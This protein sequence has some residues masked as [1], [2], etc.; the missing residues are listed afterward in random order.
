MIYDLIVLLRQNPTAEVCHKSIQFLFVM[1]VIALAAVQ[2]MLI[3]RVWYLFSDQKWIQYSMILCFVACNVLS[4]YFTIMASQNLKLLNGTI[5]DLGKHGCRASRP[6]N[7]Y[8]MFMPSLGLH[9][10]LYAL[11]AIRALRNRQIFSHAPVLK[12]LIRDG[13][14]FFFVVFATV[15]FTAVGSF[16]T[17]LPRINIT[18]IYSNYLLSLTSIAMSR[19][20]F[21]IHSLAS[22]LGS[23]T[24]W[25]LSNV[26]LSRVG[27]R[28]GRNENEIIVERRCAG[29]DDEDYYYDDHSVLD[30]GGGRDDDIELAHVDGVKVR[31]SYDTSRSKSPM[32]RLTESRVGVYDDLT[33]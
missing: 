10:M 21:S 15:T 16:L 11:T 9:T 33:W 13:G 2:A 5:F 4:L 12:R 29:P 19:I 30:I 8:R 6:P 31:R 1:N 25:L 17:Q 7:F 27:W 26:E 18:V 24:E 28:K 22:N 3:L 23:S 32:P 20:M 14:L